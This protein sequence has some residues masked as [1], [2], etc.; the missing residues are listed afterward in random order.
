MPTYDYYCAEC[1]EK[2]ED[3]RSISSRDEPL[4]APC[5][6]CESKSVKRGFEGFP[7]VGFD[8]NLKPSGEF[9]EIL[10]HM[11]TSGVVPKKYHENLDK[12]M[13]RTGV[14]Y[15][16][17]TTVEKYVAPKANQSGDTTNR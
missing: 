12:A 13:N 8:A 3:F 6:K 4:D 15:N 11:K 7:T 1:D 16:K 17:S 14:G 9:K 10:N 2:W 5:P